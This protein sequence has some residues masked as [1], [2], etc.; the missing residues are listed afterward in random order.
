MD[1]DISLVV[2]PNFNSVF[3]YYEFLSHNSSNCN[4]NNM[5]EGDDGNDGNEGDDGDD[6]YN[7]LNGLNDFGNYL[8]LYNPM[9]NRHFLNNDI[10]TNTNNTIHNLTN[11]ITNMTLS[12]N[13][14]CG[15]NK[16][17]LQKNSIQIQCRERSDCS[18]CLVSYPENTTF[19]LMTCNHSFCIECCEKWFSSN[20]SCPLCR[21][22][23][24]P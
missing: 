2:C 23:F 6:D 20:V 13:L 11:Q 7:R 21:Q 4:G 19:Y 9:I 16:N 15:L 18:I 5:D 1:L 24:T 3:Q 17:Q 14:P 10:N 22:L 12:L 8:D